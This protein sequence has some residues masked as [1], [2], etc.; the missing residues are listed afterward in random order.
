MLAGVAGGLGRHFGLDPVL[1]R[2]GFAVLALFG[3]SGLLLYVLLALLVP[4]DAP[5]ADRDPGER[6]TRTLLVI[7]GVIVVVVSL[8]IALPG[9]FFLSPFIFLAALGVIVYRAAGG[10][11]DPRAVRASVIVLTIVAAIV[12][13]FAAATAVAFGAGTVVSGI[14]LAAGVV[15]IA[16]AFFGGA[17]WLIAPALILAIPVSIVAAA[18][19]DFKGGTGQRDY[20][21]AAVADIRSDYRLGVGELRLDLS[22]VDFPAGVTT[23]RTDVGVGHVEVILPD[24]VCLDSD[25]H[26]GLG[27][28]S[29]LDRDGDGVDVDVVH[30][31]PVPSSAPVLRLESDLGM[32]EVEVHRDRGG[33]FVDERR[34]GCGPS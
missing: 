6:R 27:D 20:R 14:V 4:S 12:L 15:L 28:A 19:I 31:E 3:G 5:A 8:P 23:V 1:F 18:D 13:G 11:V 32:G 25:V 17:R 24:D 26:V 10:R 2:V 7:A 30:R 9:A 33:V 21:P 22:D 34:E 16:A 29:V